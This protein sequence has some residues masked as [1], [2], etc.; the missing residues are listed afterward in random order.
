MGHPTSETASKAPVLEAVVAVVH[1]LTESPEHEQWLLG[2]RANTRTF[3]AGKWEFIGGAKDPTEAP[4]S[5]ILRELKEETGLVPEF[6]SDVQTLT[7]T[8]PE[9]GQEVLVHWA[10][11]SVRQREVKRT[12]EHSWLGW[13][14]G[15]TVSAAVDENIGVESLRAIWDVLRS[16][17]ADG[18][19]RS[20]KRAVPEPPRALQ[21]PNVPYFDDI[22]GRQIP[23]LDHGFVRLID[24]MGDEAAIVQAARVSY[25]TGTKAV[26]EDRGLIRYLLRQRHSTPFEMI[27]IKLHVKLPI[28]VARQWIRHRTA[29]VNE[30][31]ARY[32]ILDREFY[33]PEPSVL[34]AQAT[35]NKQGRGEV[36]PPEYAERVRQLLI[37]SCTRTYDEYSDLIND[38]GTGSP[39]DPEVPQL[40]RELARMNL[41]LN[42]YTQWYWKI[43]L[44]NLLHFLGLRMDSH[45][46]YE[47]RVYADVIGGL[48]ENGY[49][50]VW[51]AFL[52][53]RLNAA[54][55]SYPQLR[56]VQEMLAEL[57]GAAGRK[58]CQAVLDDADGRLGEKGLITKR[59]KDELVQRLWPSDE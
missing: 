58:V 41:N 53:Y 38:D 3:G 7:I 35:N 36:V 18:T 19:T 44:H 27:E 55:L 43:D 40:A 23:I 49:P 26:S 33:L 30:Y 24:Y 51:D 32:S 9:D 56:L 42:Y 59:E 4:R 50:N 29:N 11:C 1:L 16:R 28:F 34:A 54:T 15:P 22:L 46:Q 10:V 45:A 13:Y 20:L 5:G 39:E 12:E 2:V 8:R 57:G 21:R 25:G 14:S 31:S 37:D 17:Q 47:I 52:D 48:I 6:V